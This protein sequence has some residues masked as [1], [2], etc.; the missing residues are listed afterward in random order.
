M[1]ACTSLKVL[2]PSQFFLKLATMSVGNWGHLK[3]WA[4]QYAYIF[5]IQYID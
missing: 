5:I 4:R 3:L 2:R 1:G